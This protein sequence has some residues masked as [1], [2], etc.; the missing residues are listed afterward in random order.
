MTNLLIVLLA[1]LGG[2]RLLVL[3]LGLRPGATAPL[4][5]LLVIRLALLAARPKGRDRLRPAGESM[6]RKLELPRRLVVE[7]P[8]T[9]VGPLL[10]RVLII[11]RAL[12]NLS[13]RHDESLLVG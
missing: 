13:R 3:E 1:T 9:L 4:G 11:R 8:R 12:T 10:R 6:L 2:R 7:L 5:V